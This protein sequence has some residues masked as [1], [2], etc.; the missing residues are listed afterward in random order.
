MVYIVQNA[1]ALFLGMLL[2]MLGNGL[3]G[4]LLAVRGGIEG[5]NAT[6]MSLVMSGYFIGMLF[7]SLRA[8]WMI[9][10]VGHVRVFAAMASLISA[11]FIVYAAV[12][13]PWVWMA[14]RVLV[15]FSFACVYVVAESWLNDVS[16]NDT[17][18]QA[19]SVYLIVQMAGIIAAQLLL[20]VGDPSGYT[21]FVVISVLVSLSFLPILLSV[22][23]AP[24]H[25]TV[26][27]MSLP[28]LYKAS[29]LGFVAA[30]AVG[31]IFGAQFGMGAVYATAK[32]YSLSEL[33]TFVAAIYVGGIIFQYPIGFISDRVD[34]RVLMAVLTT[35]G[36]LLVGAGAAFAN[37]YAVAL[38]L[39]VI[40]GGFANPLYSLIIAYVNDYLDHDD[41]PAAASGLV[42]LN[43]VGAFL[44]PLPV[45]WL[46]TNVGP[47]S[48]FIFIAMLFAGIAAYALFRMTQRPAPEAEE[49]AAYV[50]LHPQSM[51]VAADIA[52][53]VAIDAAGGEEG[54]EPAG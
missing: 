4:S 40:M 5:F 12:P 32:G 16:T 49:T 33:A 43:G 47:D 38:A 37:S 3:Q 18:G 26:K 27:R 2:L 21:L 34:R 25:D 44:G 31:A 17:R 24:V 36:A 6:M 19:L 42:F 35:A 20:G 7:G 13:D 51:A 29:P 8:P 23:A 54:T 28:A 22:S 50:V 52:Q 39:A 53:E 41:M 14:L 9:R 48:Y 45:G 15:G 10:R 46:I 11:A 1:W 30:L